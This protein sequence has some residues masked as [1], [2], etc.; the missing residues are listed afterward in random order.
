MISVIDQVLEN[1]Q[2]RLFQG[3]L[4][5]I[6]LG[7]K[8]WCSDRATNHQEEITSLESK[9]QKLDNVGSREEEKNEI[10]FSFKELTKGK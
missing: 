6:K 3:T 9:L 10:F 2:H 7:I 8:Q 1:S 5:E 4:K